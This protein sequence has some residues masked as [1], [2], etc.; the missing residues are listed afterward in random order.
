MA[1]DG[2]GDL[3]KYVQKF[4][5]ATRSS[6]RMD[7]LDKILFKWTGTENINKNSRGSYADAQKLGTLEKLY[8]Q[9]FMNVY[10]DSNPNYQNIWEELNKQYVSIRDK[11]YAQLAMQTFA[12]DVCDNLK[13]VYTKES[14]GFKLDA[15]GVREY[16]D[17][18][19]TV[20]EETAVNSFKNLLAVVKKMGW[21]DEIT[22]LTAFIEH[23]KGQNSAMEFFATAFMNNFNFLEMGDLV[24]I[25][26][27]LCPFLKYKSEGLRER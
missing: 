15:T 26:Y 11:A 14:D 8:G 23:F 19:L 18:Q 22:G 13:I 9:D 7:W 20:N 25:E 3:Y 10:G 24:I 17:K 4:I 12:K 2:T 5:A 21:Q 6:E 27:F 16:I 1:E